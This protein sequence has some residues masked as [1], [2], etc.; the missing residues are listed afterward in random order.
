VF[1][2]LLLLSAPI[3]IAD[4]QYRRIPNIYLWVLVYCLIPLLFIWGLGELIPLIAFIVGAFLMS[5]IGM[6][7]GDFKLLSI[8]GAWLNIREN[9]SLGY[10]AAL[11]LS[12]SATHILWVSF[13][14]R[15]IPNSIPMAPS[16]FLA[17]S[18]YLATQ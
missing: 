17:L 15:S 4:L 2:S 8:I 3:V 7:M 5:T 6:G 14:S 10:F 1:L 12:V 11:I 9:A 18:L 13:K 16:I